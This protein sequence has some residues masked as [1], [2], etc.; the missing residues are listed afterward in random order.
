MQFHCSTI[1]RSKHE[2]EYKCDVGHLNNPYEVHQGPTLFPGNPWI[3]LVPLTGPEVLE[4]YCRIAP[5]TVSSV[6]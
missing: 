5:P 3:P 6:N 4:A 2:R 1:W